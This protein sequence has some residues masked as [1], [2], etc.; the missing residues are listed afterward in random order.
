MHTVER[1]E[2]RAHYNSDMSGDVIFAGPGGEVNVPGDV[3]LAVAAAFVAAER[4]AEIGQMGDREI[5]TGR[6]D[7]TP[8]PPTA[9]APRRTA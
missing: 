1:G 5:L 4:I 9:A 7:P 8:G 6:H 2:W 3:V